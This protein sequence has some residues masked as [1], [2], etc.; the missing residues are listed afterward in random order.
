MTRPTLKLQAAFFATIIV[1]VLLAGFFVSQKNKFRGE[2]QA[3]VGEHQQ[4]LVKDVAADLRQRLDEYLD[5][6]Q[7]TAGQT[8]SVQFRSPEDVRRYFQSIAPVAGLFDSVFLVG[9]DG[10]VSAISPHAQRVI[11]LD[12]HDRDY[13]KQVVVVGQPTI[14]APLRNRIGGAPNIVL[15][16]PVFDETG[17]MVG[18]FCASLGLLRPNFLGDMRNARIGANGYL[19]VVQR[20]NDPVFVIHPD[21]TKLLANTNTDPTIARA[22]A[23]RPLDETEPMVSMENVIA[24]GWT[25]GSVIPRDEVDAPFAA[26]RHRFGWAAFFL[27]MLVACSVWGAMHLLLRPLGR[28]HKALRNPDRDEWSRLTKLDVG[29][30]SPEIESIVGNLRALMGEVVRQRAEL[31]AVNDASPLGFFRTRNDGQTTYINEAYRRILGLSKEAAL[32]N[33]WRE[34]LAPED[35]PRAEHAWDTARENRIVFRDNQRICIP[36][37]PERE[38]SVTAAPVVVDGKARGY[39]GVV[40][41]IT[42]RVR[43]EQS[44]AALMSVLEATP[45][46]IAQTDRD[47]KLTYI[48]PAGRAF[49]GL[50]ADK[51]I[52]ETTIADYHPPETVRTL[53]EVAVPAA[54][55]SG[56]WMGE[57]LAYNAK[58]EAVP[59]AHTVIVHR[60]ATGRLDHYSAIMRDISQERA[61]KE[62]VERNAETL[63]TVTD[64]MPGEVCF[65]GADG[66]YEFANTS[67]ARKVEMPRS[68]LIGKTV[69]EVFGIAA[70]ERLRE[71]L[72]KALAGSPQRFER[73]ERTG[74]SLAYKEVQYVPQFRPDGSVIGVHVL[75]TDITARK[76]K[77]LRL[78][79]LSETDHLTGLLN[80][81]G[82]EDQLAKAVSTDN[83]R[84]LGALLLIDLD[85]FKRVNDTYGH[86][87]GDEVLRSFADRLRTVM[88][89]TDFVARFG[90]DEFAVIVG[91]VN[92][93]TLHRLAARLISVGAR[94]YKFGEVVIE[95][96]CSIGVSRLR[97][98]VDRAAV[99]AAADD[100]L[101]RAKNLGKGRYE[102]A[103]DVA[104]EVLDLD[105]G[106]ATPV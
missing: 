105:P 96:G 69:P 95:L 52:S 34:R 16:A 22:L 18:V 68:K 28:L 37:E 78:K 87:T 72:E 10:K 90:G 63:R 8:H 73:E 94:P 45:D 41:D 88:R 33:Q 39:V 19:F 4:A 55:R 104:G 25:V 99:V 59:V 13:F 84:E 14:S 47:G 29:P 66:R 62:V 2:I 100:A 48:N 6:V 50:P 49:A 65:V 57:T 79:S 20:G 77:E 60:D 40:E 97:H 101:Y 11:G 75:I 92:D 15:A 51:E 12:V 38:I 21:D 71:P 24:V 1:A 17:H 36:G 58:R 98:N 27:I 103:D 23:G 9:M 5:L 26:M 32:A 80:R 67:Y 85:G 89:P 102:F 35:R 31:E 54:L 70:Y 76:E 64:A 81:A 53:R 74:G 106:S 61:A 7:R 46:F 44:I 42:Q 83:R 30:A 86:A 3:L 93:D 56:V 82:F 43:A 91:P